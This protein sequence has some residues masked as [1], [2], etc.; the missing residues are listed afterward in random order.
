MSNTNF[1]TSIDAPTN[2]N[3]TDLVTS[4][5]HHTQH[6]FANDA[7]VALETKIG[8]NGS[9]VTTTHDYKLSNVT[10][11]DKA[12]SDTGLSSAV[13][14]LNT[15]IAALVPAG[16]ATAFA[17]SSAPT[18][19]L[20]CDGTSLARSGMY[21]NLFAAIGTTYGSV[22][23][24]HFTL[25]DL[26]GYT[27][28]GYKSSDTNFDTLNTP[29]VYVGEKTHTLTVGELAAHTHTITLGNA[30]G[31]AISSLQSQSTYSSTQTQTSSSNGSGTAHNNMP[32]YRVMNWIIKY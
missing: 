14:T 29:S 19:W 26:R 3:A 5:A 11:T 16:V 28:Y 8:V 7:I 15:T 10:G 32:P 22:D 12:V 27:V 24:T 1:P 9:A 31:G 13:S 18:G 23:G 30:G 17:G 6:G 21:A 20:I 4:P 25:P 2:P